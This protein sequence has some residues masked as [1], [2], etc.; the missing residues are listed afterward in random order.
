MHLIFKSRSLFLLFFFSTAL[1]FGGMASAEDRSPAPPPEQ[2]A[3]RGNPGTWLAVFFRDHLSA[4]DGDRCPSLPTCSAYSVQAFKKHGFFMG[5]IM[6]VDRLIHEADERSVS[7][8]VLR[9]GK[10]R[11]LDP[12]ENNDF[13]WSHEKKTEED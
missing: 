13:W 12:V 10:L 3:D 2:T 7:P 11:T 8:T 5:W 1:V 4:V 9:G 6:N